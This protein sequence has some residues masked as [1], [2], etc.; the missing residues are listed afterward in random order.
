MMPWQC[1]CVMS[2][3][4]PWDDCTEV[5]IPTWEH[6]TWEYDSLDDIVTYED[7][8]LVEL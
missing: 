5:D 4:I 1:R 3:D 7:L 8:G 6:D 2:W